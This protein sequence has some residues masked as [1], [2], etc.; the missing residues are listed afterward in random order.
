MTK[1]EI[2]QTTVTEQSATAAI[3]EIVI[4]DA[5]LPDQRQEWI[6]LKVRIEFERNPPF[7]ELQGKALDRARSVL[8]RQTEETKS[9]AR[10]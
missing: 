4:A 7:S 8:A 3:V 9:R 1:L 2:Q 6:A 10:P 5:P